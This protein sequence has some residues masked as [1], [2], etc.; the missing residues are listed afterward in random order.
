MEGN[1]RRADSHCPARCRTHMIPLP[2]R[3]SDGARS[4][5]SLDQRGADDDRLGVRYGGKGREM[6][7]ALGREVGLDGPV[8]G[9]VSP[10]AK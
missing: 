4:V 9:S 3:P 1:P 6:A 8:L 10:G 2:R 7:C 5:L